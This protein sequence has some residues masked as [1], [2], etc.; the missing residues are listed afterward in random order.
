MSK[1]NPTERLKE[2]RDLFIR[3]EEAVDFIEHHGADFSEPWES[4]FEHAPEGAF[5]W[6]QPEAGAWVPSEDCDK[7]DGWVMNAY[8]MDISRRADGTECIK[9]WIIDEYGNR[10]TNE[11]FECPAGQKLDANEEEDFRRTS[12]MSISH[13]EELKKHIYLVHV[14]ETG[15]DPLNFKDNDCDVRILKNIKE[16]CDRLIKSVYDLPQ[17]QKAKREAAGVKVS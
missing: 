5:S 11:Q 1:P 13:Y 12:A 6:K 17:I 7:D 14:T 16:E 9:F 10:E 15:E 8:G 2:L 4:H 3:L